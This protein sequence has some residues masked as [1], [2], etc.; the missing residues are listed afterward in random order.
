MASSHSKLHCRIHS[1]RPHSASQGVRLFQGCHQREP[2][3]RGQQQAS[4]APIQGSLV[5]VAEGHH[6]SLLWALRYTASL[7]YILRTVPFSPPRGNQGEPELLQLLSWQPRLLLWQQRCAPMPETSSCSQRSVQQAS[8]ANRHQEISHHLLAVCQPE[9]A[10]EVGHSRKLL[11][12]S[13]SRSTLAQKQRILV[14]TQLT[15][16]PG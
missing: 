8:P 12:P 11:I 10:K 9:V 13:P 5:A 4:V 7:G 15:K 16:Q 3:Q 1:R 14:Q 2:R 6:R